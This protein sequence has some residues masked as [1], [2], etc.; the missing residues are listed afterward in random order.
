MIGTKDLLI[1]LLDLDGPFTQ[2]TKRANEIVRQID[3]TFPIV[4][5]SGWET[6]SHI[7]TL[8][9]FSNPEMYSVWLQ[10]LH[11]PGFYAGIEPVPGS[12]EEL[13]EIEKIAEVFFCSTPDRDNPTCANDKLD[14]V[15][16][17]PGAHFVPRTI[18]TK[19]KTLVYGDTI[20]EDNPEII[21]LRDGS[22]HTPVPWWS[23]RILYDKPYNQGV[24]G[25]R[26]SDGW[27]G[28]EDAF[29]AVGVIS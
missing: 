18:L 11:T 21:G 24:A 17:H 10:A 22:S 3:P 27:H 20:V 14:W 4:E 15:R 23:R 5:E 7:K 26:I 16:E 6:Y 8:Y 28:W 1:V 25:V 19:D 13:R 29:R 2:W 12:L 9:E